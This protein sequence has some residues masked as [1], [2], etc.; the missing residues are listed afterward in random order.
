MS[1]VVSGYAEGAST[2]T[3][4]ATAVKL[5]ADTLIVD[6]RDKSATL[7]KLAYVLVSGQIDTDGSITA[8]RIAVRTRDT[9]SALAQITLIGT[10]ADY[11]S[12]ASFVVRGVPFL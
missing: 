1:G 4:G 8:T 10:I 12:D 7:S 3:V 2:F 6:G 11:L 9:D 5:T